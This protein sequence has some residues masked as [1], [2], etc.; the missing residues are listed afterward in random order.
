MLCVWSASTFKK[1]QKN[2]V[3]VLG[4]NEII[5]IILQILEFAKLEQITGKR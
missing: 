5:H 4:A 3:R 2:Q 1:L